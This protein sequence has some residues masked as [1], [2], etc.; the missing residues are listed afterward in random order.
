LWGHGLT[1]SLLTLV[2]FVPALLYDFINPHFATLW[3][4]ATFP[5]TII[6]LS[7]PA[8]TVEDSQI[9]FLLSRFTTDHNVLDQSTMFSK[10]PSV[11]IPFG[12][13]LVF[14]SLFSLRTWHLSHPPNPMEI[15][16]FC[17]GFYN[18]ND[19][20]SVFCSPFIDHFYSLPKTKN[21][22]LNCSTDI[23][24]RKPFIPTFLFPSNFLLLL[25][26]LFYPQNDWEPPSSLALGFSSNTYFSFLLAFFFPL[27]SH[28]S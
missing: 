2:L 8:R 17:D 3:N 16:C 1:N 21:P 25:C 28:S 11:T 20:D 27:L 22:L 4:F 19:A 10:S 7:R 5:C 26:S 15:D 9:I 24:P 23:S 14:C 12:I 18:K 6:F 13:S